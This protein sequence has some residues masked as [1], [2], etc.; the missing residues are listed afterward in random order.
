MAAIIEVKQASEVPMRSIFGFIILGAVCVTGCRGTTG[1]VANKSRTDKPDDPLF[2]IDEQQKR[3]RDR[4][5]Y[6]DDASG[7]QGAL[8]NRYGPTGR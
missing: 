7:P 2:T 8:T 4:Y 1:P 6:P 5:S 3:G